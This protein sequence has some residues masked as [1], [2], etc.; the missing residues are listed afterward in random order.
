MSSLNAE[1]A[2]EY[3]EALGLLSYPPIKYQV[4]ARAKRSEERGIE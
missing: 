1:L 2:R 4:S 3:F